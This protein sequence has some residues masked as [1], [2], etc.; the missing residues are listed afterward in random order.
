MVFGKKWFYWNKEIC[1]AEVSTITRFKNVHIYA[2]FYYNKFAH[3]IKKKKTK[4]KTT[5]D[6]LILH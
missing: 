5:H 2:L 3:F 6:F 1:K 4:K